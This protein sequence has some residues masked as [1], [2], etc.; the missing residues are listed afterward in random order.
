MRGFDGVRRPLGLAIIA[1]AA[2]VLAACSSSTSSTGGGV[3]SVAA[4]LEQAKAGACEKL[5]DASTAVASAQAGQSGE[6]ASKAATL[7]TD[8]QAAAS[9]LRTLGSSSVA[10]QMSAL[11]TDI[12]SLATAAPADRDQLATGIQS[13]IKS[14]QA[15]LAC[16]SGSGSVTASSSPSM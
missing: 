2:I 11:A 12:Q 13:E 3:S 4:G 16:P 1:L 5:V 8:L 7:A 10:D 14:I 9:L 15:G 6:Y